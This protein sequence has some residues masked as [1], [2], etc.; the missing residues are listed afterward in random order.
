MVSK[1]MINAAK[2][3]AQQRVNAA[4]LDFSSTQSLRSSGLKPTFFKS[5]AMLRT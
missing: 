3:S 1:S 2:N 5:F 4:V